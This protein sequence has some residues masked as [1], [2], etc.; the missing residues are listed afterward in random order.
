MDDLFV[1]RVEVEV[2]MVLCNLLSMWDSMAGLDWMFVLVGG[3]CSGCWIGLH[4]NEFLSIVICR[5]V[6]YC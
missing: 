3:F 6:F 2:A 1:T 4:Y 5:S